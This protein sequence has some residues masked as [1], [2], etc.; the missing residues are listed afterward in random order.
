MAISHRP[1][2]DEQLAELQ[3]MVLRMG[4]VALEMVKLAGEAAATGNLE[5]A[6][7]VLLMDDEVDQLQDEIVAAAMATVMRETPVANDLKR[8]T[9]TIGIVGEI[10]KVGDDAVKL[11]RRSAKLAGVFPVE[12]R[13]PF[14]EMNERAR[15][16]FSTALHL[17]AEYSDDVAKQIIDSDEAIDARYQE[18]RNLAKGLIRSNPDAVSG[19]LRMIDAFHALEH[20]ADHAVEIASRLRLHYTALNPPEAPKSRPGVPF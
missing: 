8:L 4:N 5:I 14:A 1:Q 2:Y 20:V 7:R 17:Y 11:A 13:G 12:L 19:M 15:Q 9:G 3:A 6:E 18:V 16:L 10:E